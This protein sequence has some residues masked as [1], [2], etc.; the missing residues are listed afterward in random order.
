MRSGVRGVR[1]GRGGRGAAVVVAIVA[2]LVLSACREDE[3]ALDVGAPT[4][5]ER[6][7]STVPGAPSAAECPDAAP[8]EA[9]EEEEPM[10]ATLEVRFPD[11]LPAGQPVTWTISVTSHED[12][13]V[14]LVFPSGQDGD[15][16]LERAGAAEPVYR[17]SDGMFFTQALRCRE[18]PAGATLTFEL[19]GESLDV[20][21]G[22][23][24][25]R[26][27]LAATPAPPPAEQPV[28]VTAN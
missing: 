20:E 27:T 23:Y 12:E 16:V 13:T 10:D 4:S 6:T 22:D 9:G 24:T 2:A 18:L 14:T 19:Q 7:S 28:T 1:G 21:P 15:V 17:W 25:L 5:T 8:A 11:P 3:P 26:A